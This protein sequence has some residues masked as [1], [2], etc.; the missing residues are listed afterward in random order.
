MN[1]VIS[2]YLHYSVKDV[3]SL[4]AWRQ[5]QA[6]RPDNSLFHAWLSSHKEILKNI[7]KMDHFITAIFDNQSI[8]SVFVK[9]ECSS[10]CIK[11]KGNAGEIPLD[12]LSCL[13]SYPAGWQPA[14]LLQFRS[15]TRVVSVY[16]P[17][18]I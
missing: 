1:H 13:A 18:K 3:I 10:G 5:H 15:G 7:F 4:Q 8:S 14:D 12:P 17:T 11:V 16:K 2:R 9:N 6:Y